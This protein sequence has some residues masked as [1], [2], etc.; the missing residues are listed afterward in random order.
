MSGK[1]DK[2]RQRRRRA[3]QQLHAA[4]RRERQ[5]Q[6][7]DVIRSFVTALKDL[8]A[9]AADEAIAPEGFAQRL[10]QAL[11]GDDVVASLLRDP[12]DAWRHAE[13]IATEVGVE[14][15]GALADT[16]CA[17]STETSPTRW[18]ACGLLSGSDDDRRAEE[19]ATATLEAIGPD[20]LNVGVAHLVVSQRLQ[21]DRPADALDLACSLVEADPSDTEAQHLQALSLRDIAARDPDDHALQSSPCPCGAL[22]EPWTVCCQPRDREAVAHFANRERLYALRLGV[23]AFIAQDPVLERHLEESREE[24]AAALD[25]PGTLPEFML[26][27]GRSYKDAGHQTRELLALER[28][29]VA[30]PHLDEEEPLDMRV[31]DEDDDAGAILRLYA[32]DDATPRELAVLADAWQESAICGLW[33]VADPSGGPNLWLM[34]IVTG[35]TRWVSMAP[36]Q[37]EGAGRWSVLAGWV[38]PD[39]GVWRSGGAFV[40][41]SPDEGDIAA[42]VLGAMAEDV[43]S[44]M[45]RERRGRKPG[46]SSQREPKLGPPPAHGILSGWTDGLDPVVASLHHTILGIALP[47]VVATAMEGHRRP[48]RLHNTD[49]QS[50]ELLRAIGYADD[51]AALRAALQRRS[52]FD[53]GDEGRIVWRGREMTALE[54]ETSLAEFGAFA[55][56]GGISAD[57]EEDDGPRYWVRGSV[58]IDGPEIT[59]E[60]NSRVRLDAISQILAGLGVGPLVVDQRFDPSVD[61]AFPSG[62]RPLGVAGSPEAEEAWRRNWLDE[63]LPA[64]GGVTPRQAVTDPGT[65]VELERL[66]RRLEFDADLAEHRGQ[67]PLD[68]ERIRRDLGEDGRLF[69]L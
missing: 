63:T 64:L 6:T 11:S 4:A 29:W 14:R 2:K 47:D 35:E 37:L 56:D 39:R 36:E 27:P 42:E 34:D 21:L 52:D 20:G 48:P 62:W 54:A 57:V 7:D 24:W 44:A 1:R 49:G 55:A 31:D 15:A 22:A 66:L 40:L 53:A 32:A 25:D 23:G 58:D 17:N 61:M 69:E 3:D 65:A 5:R 51:P 41:L 38:V 46:R 68:V 19:V 60:V 13:H 8:E 18:W 59:I 30:A 45:L 43:A 50:L 33:Q 26:D 16:L 10:E 9:I 12:E 67:R 28:A